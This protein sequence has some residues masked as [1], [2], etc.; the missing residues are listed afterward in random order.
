MIVAAFVTIFIICVI[1]IALVVS[2]VPATSATIRSVAPLRS[3]EPPRI[4]VVVVSYNNW[5]YVDNTITQLKKYMPSDQIII[6]DNRS[7]D[8]KTRQ[9][10]DS[11][12]IRV[13]HQKENVGPWI[14]DTKNRNVYDEMPDQFALTDPDLQFHPDLPHDFLHILYELST[15]HRAY[16]VGFA[17]DISEPSLLYQDNDY[18][19]G[20]SIVDWESQFWK[21]HIPDSTH[22]LYE[23][24]IDTTFALI[25]KKY[26]K[27]KQIRVAGRFTAKHLPWYVD[28]PLMTVEEQEQQFETSRY[29]TIA[30]LFYRHHSN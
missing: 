11:T 13:I 9:Y 7:S 29:S 26:M 20:K 3:L 21:R 27:G 14:T 16:K 6:M 17:L 18:T 5:R 25:N 22:D 28:N 4:P 23:A 24:E 15:Q 30:R 2:E 8:S 19:K 12:P 10:L 1:T